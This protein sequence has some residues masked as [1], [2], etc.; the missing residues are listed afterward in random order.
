[1]TVITI[2]VSEK[3]RTSPKEHTSKCG[4]E[5]LFVIYLQIF[6]LFTKTIVL[7]FINLE[8]FLKCLPKNNRGEFG[9]ENV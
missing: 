1:M 5:F 2:M 7:V 9:N 4:K 8:K 3:Y 6:Q